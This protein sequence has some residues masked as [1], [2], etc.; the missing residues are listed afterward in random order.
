M[1]TPQA[2]EDF[3]TFVERKIAYAKVTIN[4]VTEKYQICRT[5]RLNNEQ[6]RL[7]IEITPELPETAVVEKVQLYNTDQQLWAEKEERIELKEVQNGVLYRF[8][9]G[10]VEKEV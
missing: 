8:T 4:G 5:E 1:L 10:F 6:I 9:F 3:K 7:Y 2:I